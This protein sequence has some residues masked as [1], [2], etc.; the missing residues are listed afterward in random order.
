[1]PKL[2]MAMEEGTIVT[3]LKREG[4]Q[5]EAGDP[6]LVIETEKVNMEVEAAASGILLR[7]TRAEGQTVP[8]TETIGWIGQ[9]GEELPEGEPSATAGEQAPARP[10]AQPADPGSEQP[11]G[12][13]YGQAQPDLPGRVPATPAARRLAREK[14]VDLGSVAPSGGSGEVRLR[15]VEALASIRTTPVARKMA[16]DLGVDLAGLRGTGPGGKIVEADVRAALDGSGPGRAGQSGDLAQAEPL[17]GM[18][19]TIGQRMLANHLNIPPVT[20]VA[21]ADLTELV[22]I[23]KRFNQARETRISLND[24]LLKVTALALA[25]HPALNTTLEEDRLVRHSRVN[26]GLAVALEKG[27]IVPVIHG[28]EAMSLPRISDRARELT[29]KSRTGRLVPDECTGGTFTLTNMGGFGIYSFTP[30]INAPQVAILG[31]GALEEKLVLVEGR[32]ERRLIMDLSLTFDHRAM[33]GVTAALFQATV[34]EYLEN[35]YRLLTF[36]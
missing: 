32:V 16:L 2:G 15:D 33:D 27:L 13:P 12:Q 20:Q 8:V 21:K 14:G 28:A 3:W 7:I 24:I 1:M 36:I 22:E 30:I 9:A 35:P 25:E 4:D 10:D 19:R 5:V 18:R 17:S 6:L 34:K 26:L 31:A 23:R 11:S 29:E